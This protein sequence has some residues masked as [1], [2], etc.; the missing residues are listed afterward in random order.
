ML[1]SIFLQLVMALMPPNTLPSEADVRLSVPVLLFT[2]AACALSGILFGAA[3]AW[4]GSRVNV[5]AA[6]KES[7]RSVAKGRHRLQRALVAI[8]FALA[9]T[10]LAGGGLAL[11]GLV[12]LSRV[13]LGFQT[14]SLLTFALPVPD[15]RLQGNDAV[16]VFYSDLLARLR[17]TPAVTA[18]SV[19]TGMPVLGPGFGMP[20]HFAG[21]P[22]ADPSERQG[23]G[24]NMVSPGYFE[25]FGIRMVKGRPFNEHDRAGAPPVA[26]VNQAFVDRYLKD[27]EPL[28]QRLVIPQLVAGEIRFGPPLEWQIVGVY[29]DVRNAGPGDNGFPEIDVPF[30]QSP[31]PAARVA[32][33]TIGDPLMVTQSVASVVR[34]MDVDLPMADVKTMEQRVHESMANDRFNTVLFGTFAGLA[35]VLAAVGIYGVMSFVVAERRQEIGIRLALGAG[36]TRVLRSVVRDGMLTAIAGTALGSVG[37]YFVGRAMQGLVYGVGTVNWV[38]FTAVALILTA[39]ALVAC[40]IPA[41]RAAKVDPLTALREE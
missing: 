23:A 22:P 29:G 2:V 30:L 3:P 5:N 41:G 19:S 37:A 18:A 14:E 16:T 36:R 33:R 10:L 13:N 20:F 24:F 8:E 12:S 15:G 17:A 25:T 28:S 26:V 11:N 35:L 7:G 1:S 38:T 4:Q 39:T 40:L 21:K 31:W 32:V 6:L 9:L 34:A 27:V